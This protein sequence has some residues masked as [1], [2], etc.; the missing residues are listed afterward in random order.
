[1][2]LSKYVAQENFRS[3]APVAIVHGVRLHNYLMS[4]LILKTVAKDS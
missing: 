2:L 3:A 1:M 4:K